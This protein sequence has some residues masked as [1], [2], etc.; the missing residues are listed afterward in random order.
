MAVAW[1]KVRAALAQSLPSALP[2]GFKFSNGPIVGGDSPRG[3]FT[4]GHAPSTD[5]DSSGTFIQANGPDGYVVTESGFIT[6]ELGAVTGSANMPSVFAAFDALVSRIQSD[7]TLGG[8]LAPG[9][10]VTAEAS[11]V[12]EQTK[13]G[14]VQRLIVTIQYLTNI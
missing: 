9:S 7:M 13:S 8:V 12:E 4:L 2:A 5:D 10:T 3:Y 6:G 14:A 1:P 11:V